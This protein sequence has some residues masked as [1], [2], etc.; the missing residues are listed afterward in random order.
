MEGHAMTNMQ[1]KLYVSLAVVVSHVA[2]FFGVIMLRIF[3]LPQAN[4]FEIIGAMIPLFGVFLIVII[5][6]TVRGREDLSVGNI[7]TQQMTMITFVILGAYC[8]AVGVTFPMVIEQAIEP[9]ELPKWLAV[10]ESAFG[11]ALG[12]I[13]DELFGGKSTGQNPLT[14]AGGLAG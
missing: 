8:V 13:I 3:V 6:D 12:L 7:Q 11:T 2:T 14:R 9:A 5:K 4:V 10:I 1:L